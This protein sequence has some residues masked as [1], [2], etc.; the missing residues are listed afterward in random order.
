MLVIKIKG[1]IFDI[2]RFSTH[3]G[4][5]I[6][7]AIF[8]KGCPLSCIWC[9]SPE[10]QKAMPELIYQNIRCV[11]CRRCVGI[12]PEKAI[13]VIDDKITINREM[14]KSCFVCAKSCITHA[15]NICGVW[16]EVDDIVEII[17]QDKPFYIN[18]GGGITITG[19]ELLTQAEF[20]I[21]LLTLCKQAGIHTAIETCGFGNKNALLKIAGLCD[22]IYY[23]IKF[24][25]NELHKKYTSAGNSIILDNLAALCED[26]ADKIIIRVPCIPDINDSP[27]QL[28]EIAQLARKYGIKC[29]EL[30][31]YNAGATAKYEWVF[32]SYELNDTKPRQQP[33][34]DNLAEMINNILRS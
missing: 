7:A 26:D 32:R 25:N 19:G 31:P 1:L 12:C 29:V 11:Q 5:G 4:P 24:I 28:A 6:R 33:Y 15:L 18:S 23:D 14:C 10:S 27:E 17:M 2:D 8:L 22:L 16:H 9:H 30:M 3:D 34:Y 13:S 21:E 20:V